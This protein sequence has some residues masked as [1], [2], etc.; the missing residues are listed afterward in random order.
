[1]RKLT[2]GRQHSTGSAVSIRIAQLA[3]AKGAAARPCGRGPG[4]LMLVW[5][6]PGERRDGPKEAVV[7]A[8]K[9]AAYRTFAC[10]LDLR[11][12]EVEEA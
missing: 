9:A 6:E 7:A 11:G 8:L 3:H 2:T 1:M 12:L 5:A 4:S 10:R